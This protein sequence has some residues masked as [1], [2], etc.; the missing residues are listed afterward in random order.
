MLV[1]FTSLVSGLI[2]LVRDKS[3]S[4]RAVKAL[5][6][7]IG[8]SVTLFIFLFVAFKLNWLSPHPI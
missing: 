3:D 5:T 6:W 1:I 2:F 4:K 8:L 7:R